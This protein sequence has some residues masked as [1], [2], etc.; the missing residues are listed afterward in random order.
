MS[1]EEKPWGRIIVATDPESGQEVQIGRIIK[2]RREFVAD[3]DFSLEPDSLAGSW[4]H[5]LHDGAILWKGVVVAELQPGRYLCHIDVLE[6]GA[7]QIQRVFSLDTI[8][9]LGEEAKRLIE[10]AFAAE[11]GRAPIIDPSVEWRLYD[12]EESANSAFVAWTL[13]K[14]RDES[15]V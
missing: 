7:E 10:N 6:E 12:S 2:K 15:R 11:G 14:E 8:M 1:V 3:E 4:F 9:G 13:K 5:V